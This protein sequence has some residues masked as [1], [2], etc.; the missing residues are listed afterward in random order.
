MH[1][2]ASGPAWC[3][4]YKGSLK[5]SMTWLAPAALVGAACTGCLSLAYVAVYGIPD[6]TACHA[7]PC[8]RVACNVQSRQCYVLGTFACLRQKQAY[9]SGACQHVQA[10]AHW[11]ETW[12]VACFLHHLVSRQLRQGW[13]ATSGRVSCAGRMASE[14]P[15]DHYLQLMWQHFTADSQGGLGSNRPARCADIVSVLPPCSVFRQATLWVAARTNHTT[16]SCA[17]TPVTAP[18]G[19]AMLAHVRSR[20]GTFVTGTFATRA[21]QSHQIEAAAKCAGLMVTV[22]G[23]FQW[24]TGLF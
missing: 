9:T 20:H 10:D 3:C 8:T 18:V 23:G 12:A 21:M 14:V 2:T 11:H 7:A 22:A 6:A 4:G 15:A 5:L 17:T 19:M 16:A 24:A 1:D 13:P